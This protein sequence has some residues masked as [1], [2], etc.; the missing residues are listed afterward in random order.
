MI[1]IEKDRA[2]DRAGDGQDEDRDEI[3]RDAILPS[4]SLW[5]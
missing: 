5:V 1:K 4:G 2:E 3:W